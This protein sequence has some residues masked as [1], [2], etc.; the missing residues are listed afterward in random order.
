M[1]DAGVERLISVVA[2]GGGFGGVEDEDGDDSRTKISPCPVE[3]W[4]ASM[5][6]YSKEHYSLN[7]GVWEMLQCIRSARQPGD[8]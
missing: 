5:P 2:D 6:R 8:Y 3:L 4:D 7:M 1:F